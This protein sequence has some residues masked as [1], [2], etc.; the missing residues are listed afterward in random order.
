MGTVSR[1]VHVVRRARQI[2]KKRA[3]AGGLG[4]AEADPQLGVVGSHSQNRKNSMRC[5]PYL[6]GGA[7][8]CA[9]LQGR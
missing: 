7:Q 5:C 9:I 2:V 1:P 4:R 6:N 3:E 8:P